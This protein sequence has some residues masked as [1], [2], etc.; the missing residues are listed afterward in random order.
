[1]LCVLWDCRR[2]RVLMWTLVVTLFLDVSLIFINTT[3]FVYIWTPVGT[4]F[5]DVSLMFVN[6]TL[7]VYFYG[8]V[9]LNFWLWKQAVVWLDH[10]WCSK[11]HPFAVVHGH[12]HVCHWSMA[13]SMVSLSLC[14]SS[15]MSRFSFCL[16][17]LRLCRIASTSLVNTDIAKELLALSECNH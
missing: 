6:T 13:S 4:V 2:L 7:F 8:F 14:I 3:L 9:E 1:M 12:S 11:W 15:S 5:L 17:S 10:S 16:M